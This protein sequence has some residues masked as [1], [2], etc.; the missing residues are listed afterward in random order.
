MAALND[1]EQRNQ[2]VMRQ[3]HM[4]IERAEYDCALAKRR[5][6]EVDPS[7]RLVAAKP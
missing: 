1:L 6:E 5:Y 4:R 3:W 2:A 7:N